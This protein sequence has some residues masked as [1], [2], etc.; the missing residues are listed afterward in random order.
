MTLKDGQCSVI[1]IFF[2]R[3]HHRNLQNIV[4][5]QK[6]GVLQ[7]V[8]A[9]LELDCVLL[10]VFESNKGARAFYEEKLKYGLDRDD[11]SLFGREECYRLLFKSLP[12]P[13]PLGEAN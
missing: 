1:V 5:N 13:K 3:F 2:G 6:Q 7:L 11:P 10:T 4:M 12:K 8:G 9:K